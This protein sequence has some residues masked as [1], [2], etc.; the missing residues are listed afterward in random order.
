[1]GVVNV[2]LLDLNDTKFCGS[3]NF[4]FSMSPKVIENL[5]L[6]GAFD[7]MSDDRRSLLWEVGLT[8]VPPSKQLKLDISVENNM[9]ILPRLTDW[10]SMILE[11]KTLNL[12]PKGHFMAMLR[13]H[14]SEEFLDSKQIRL[15]DDGQFVKVSG[16]V[17]RPL[18]HP[19]SQAYFITLEDEFGFIPLLI[20][21]NVYEENKS[22]L[23]E[24]IMFVSGIVSQREGTLNI[25]VKDVMIP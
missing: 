6:S 18:Q 3:I 4:F 25:I 7:S 1:M 20:W 2:G 13:P 8:Y 11:Y 19:L 23:H 10:E 5:I 9:A 16:V 22:K 21:R 12:Y 15:K 14:L 24:P 17:A